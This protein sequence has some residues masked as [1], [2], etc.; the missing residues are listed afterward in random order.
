MPWD[1]REC[2]ANSWK[3]ECLIEDGNKLLFTENTTLSSPSA[4]SSVILGRQ[5]PGPISWI[6]EKSCTYKEIQEGTI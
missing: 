3:K 4:A 2:E 1:G 5:A 6:N